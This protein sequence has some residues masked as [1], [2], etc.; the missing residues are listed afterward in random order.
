MEPLDSLEV[1]WILSGALGATVREWFGRFPGRTERREDTYLVFPPLDGLSL[2]FRAGRTLE[3]KCYLGSAGLLYLPVRGLGRLESWRKWSFADDLLYPVDRPAS[4]WVTVR[5]SRRSIW[6]PLPGTRAPVPGRPPPGTGCMAELTE[7]DVGGR[8]MWTIGL[9]ATGSAD[10]LLGAIQ[11][12]VGRLFA[13]P[14]PSEARFGLGNSWSYVQ[15]LYWQAGLDVSSP[16]L[17]AR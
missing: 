12:A 7:A 9:E 4:A 10:H 5:K 14:L 15:W 3:V 2:K 1:R 16:S 11:H 17:A 13:A 8:P 6:F